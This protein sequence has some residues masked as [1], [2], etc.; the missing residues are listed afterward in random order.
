MEEPKEPEKS[1]DKKSAI[2]ESQKQK[3][4]QKFDE[5]SSSL[6]RIFNLPTITIPE[7]L[8]SA[9]RTTFKPFY[10]T[11]SMLTNE[12]LKNISETINKI[13]NNDSYSVLKKI[14]QM[15]DE[16][17]KAWSSVCRNPFEELAQK[18]EKEKLAYPGSQYNESKY[19]KEINDN[20]RFIDNEEKNQ[21]RASKPKKYNLTKGIIMIAD[22]LGTKKSWEYKN[23]KDYVEKI[24]EV[25]RK[26]DSLLSSRCTF[27]NE[28]LQYSDYKKNFEIRYSCNFISDTFV[29]ILYQHTNDANDKNIIKGSK[30]E[31][32]NAKKE[33]LMILPF[34]FS[35]A[36]NEFMCFTL[37]K[38]IFIRGAISE[39]LL[40]VHEG[41]NNKKKNGENN[42]NNANRIYIGPAATDA[43]EIFE[44]AEWIGIVCT[45]ST[46]FS[47]LEKQ[48]LLLS[49]VEKNPKDGTLNYFFSKINNYV[50]YD[51]PFKHR[52]NSSTKNGNNNLMVLDWPTYLIK[53]YK[54]SKRD[55][56]NDIL[57]KNF[58][59]TLHTNP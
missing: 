1:F 53:K 57:Y 46:S 49:N 36:I 9:I 45:T 25:R 34:L 58:S 35:S 40:Y 29:G 47:I 42:Y 3:Q 13:Y 44:M 39:G 21:Y 24:E 16:N 55:V 4:D 20:D 12:A 43:A 11:S 18:N 17:Q 50:L 8:S 30:N 31:A 27:I 23:I 28:E 19:Y 56:L 33:Q 7:S 59:N 37:S 38:G 10:P 2:E 5:L 54:N 6:N 15:L 14:A 48:K 41:D 51:V 52:D 26:L 32:K 22:C